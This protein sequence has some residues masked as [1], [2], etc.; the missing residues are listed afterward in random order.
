MVNGLGVGAPRT[1]SPASERGH[2]KDSDPDSALMPLWGLFVE[3][4]L[5][6]CQKAAF[7]RRV[8]VSNVPTS[9]TALLGNIDRLSHRADFTRHCSTPRR[10]LGRRSLWEPDEAIDRSDGRALISP[11]ASVHCTAVP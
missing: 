10:S 9:L 6:G 3:T 8:G 1:L 4:P 2:A 7:N 11:L 5:K